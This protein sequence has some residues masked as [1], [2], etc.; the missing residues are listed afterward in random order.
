M[1]KHYYDIYE[2]KQK[3]LGLKQFLSMGLFCT[4]RGKP[5]ESL[6]M[7]REESIQLISMKL[8]EVTSYTGKEIDNHFNVQVIA[9][10]Q[11]KNVHGDL[12]T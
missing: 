7:S 1:R 10:V 2:N 11:I 12:L 6:V 5:F 9:S 3:E 8:V 4:L